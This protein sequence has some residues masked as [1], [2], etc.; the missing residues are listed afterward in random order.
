MKI[1]VG[2]VV[3]DV[4][5]VGELIHVTCGWVIT[6]HIVCGVVSAVRYITDSYARPVGTQSV[7]Q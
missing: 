6:H 3:L 7:S 1:E 2:T 4:A 5:H